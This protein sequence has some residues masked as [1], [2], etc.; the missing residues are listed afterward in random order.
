MCVFPLNPVFVCVCVTF[1]HEYRSVSEPGFHGDSHNKAARRIYGRGKKKVGC[2]EVLWSQLPW[3]PWRQQLQS[4]PNGYLMSS[5]AL[6]LTHCV[7]KQHA[8]LLQSHTHRQTVM[9]R[10][11]L[12]EP[13][14]DLT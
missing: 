12:S 13:E 10:C 11:G 4:T 5:D 9:D 6:G 14:F 7:T 2:C 1:V 8:S 3:R